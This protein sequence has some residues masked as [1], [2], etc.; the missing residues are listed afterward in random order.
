[1][2]RTFDLKTDGQRWA[3]Q[4]ESEMDRGVFVSRT[5]AEATTLAQ[6]LER[7]AQEVAPQK[8][9]RYH[10]ALRCRRLSQR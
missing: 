5:E 1:M 2:A 4:I 6:A 10:D 3:K 7:Y 9:D 8:K